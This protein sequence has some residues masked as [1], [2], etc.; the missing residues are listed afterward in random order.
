MR[1]LMVPNRSR[2]GFPCTSSL[3]FRSRPDNPVRP[4]SPHRRLCGHWAH[5]KFQ[6][7]RP[8]QG[9]DRYD[10]WCELETN[11]V[12]EQSRSIVPGRFPV[13]R[14]GHASIQDYNSRL[15]AL[16]PGFS[17]DELLFREMTLWMD[18]QASPRVRYLCCYAPYANC[19]FGPPLSPSQMQDVLGPKLILAPG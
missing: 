9:V 10:P 16:A 19:R 7:D 2:P 17:C 11:E 13:A 4:C 14:I 18:R 1:H 5:V 15:P 6:H 3:V 12:S 8:V